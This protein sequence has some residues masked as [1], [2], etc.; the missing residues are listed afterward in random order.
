MDFKFKKIYLVLFII[1]TIILFTLTSIPKLHTPINDELN[2]DKAA[3]LFV[4]A[5]FAFLFVKMHK[6]KQF[7]LKKLCL[8]AAI[9]PLF[10]ELHQI[11]ISG[12]TFSYLDIAADIL[13]FAIIFF[14][15]RLR[16]KY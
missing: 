4:Y 5:M 15:F 2:I 3:H 9:V 8:L 13:G 6:E 7:V 14:Y 12:R 11:P 10:D 16:K 1:W